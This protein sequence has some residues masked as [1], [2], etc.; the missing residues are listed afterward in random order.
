MAEIEPEK[1]AVA[2]WKYVRAMLEAHGI[3][4]NDIEMCGFHYYS[5][6][7]HGY[8]HGVESVTASRHEGGQRE[9]LFMEK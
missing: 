8:K 7:I 3:D 4:K 2:H 6:F 1:L 5:A 9:S